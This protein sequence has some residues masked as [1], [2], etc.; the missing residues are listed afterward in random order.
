MSLNKTNIYDKV[1]LVFDMCSSS[2]IIEDLTLT[3]N[4]DKLK[5][6]INKLKKWLRLKSKDYRYEIYKYIGD[7]WIL[8]F[9]VD[10]TGNEIINFLKKLNSFYDGT[11]KSI[12]NPYLERD[13][14]AT[15]LTFGIE[16][17]PLIELIMLGKR[18]FFGRALNIAF[19]LQNA[20]KVKG[21]FPDYPILVSNQVY[22]E[23]LR[24]AGGLKKAVRVYRRLKNI[25]DGGR[26]RCVKLKLW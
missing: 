25:R 9:P 4:I 2:N 13:L 7:G 21:G 12:I 17:G 16:K 19:R 6:F 20:V 15:G 8:L 24:K 18:E 3:S 1:I 22:N 5:I 26:F 10:I 11:I 23:Y 14:E